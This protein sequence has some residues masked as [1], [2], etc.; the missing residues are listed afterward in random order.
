M[1]HCKFAM[2]DAEEGRIGTSYWASSIED[3]VAPTGG[4]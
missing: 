2:C 3:I 1:L 4:H